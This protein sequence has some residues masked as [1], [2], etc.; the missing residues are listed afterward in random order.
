MRAAAFAAQWA[1]EHEDPVDPLS[2]EFPR[3]IAAFEKYPT[4]VQAALLDSYQDHGQWHE[5]PAPEP[6]A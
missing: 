3:L 4:T 5:P 1:T 6:E 2:S